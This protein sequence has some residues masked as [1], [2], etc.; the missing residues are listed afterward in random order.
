MG[1]CV[2]KL[3]AKGIKCSML[4]GSMSINDR[5]SNLNR[6]EEGITNVIATTNL[7]SRGVSFANITAV[8]N[9]ELAKNRTNDPCVAS[10]LHRSSRCG[11]FGSKGVCISFGE[12]NEIRKLENTAHIKIQ[13]IEM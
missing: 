9:Y 4:M 10:Y 6:F 8:I 5:R 11:R 1:K 3:E 12:L 13:K 2:A 7:L